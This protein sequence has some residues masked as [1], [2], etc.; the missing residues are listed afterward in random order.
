MYVAA[1]MAGRVV[2]WPYG[3]RGNP[4]MTLS[5]RDLF[6][7]TSGAILGWAVERGLDALEPVVLSYF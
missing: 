2:G 6:L 1:S 7:I 4:N 3:E 5:F